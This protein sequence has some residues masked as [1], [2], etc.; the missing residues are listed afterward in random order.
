M[1]GFKAIPKSIWEQ[2]LDLVTYPYSDQ[3][4]GTTMFGTI[5]TVLAVLAVAY[6]AIGVLVFL[7]TFLWPDNKFPFGLVKL[8]VSFVIGVLWGPLLA[9][10]TYNRFTAARNLKNPDR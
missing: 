5:V 7:K 9:L 2:F 4:D 3:Q 1:L 8:W 6:A 10:I